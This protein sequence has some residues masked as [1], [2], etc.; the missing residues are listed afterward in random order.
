MSKLKSELLQFWDYRRNSAIKPDNLGLCSN[1]RAWWHHGYCA[2]DEDH[3]WQVSP[4][5]VLSK[6]KKASRTHCPICQGKPYKTILHMG[7]TIKIKMQENF[8]LLSNAQTAATKQRGLNLE[9][10]CMVQNHE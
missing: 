6:S 5:N 7:T 10:V 3:V 9:F 4:N 1:R 2:L 8:L